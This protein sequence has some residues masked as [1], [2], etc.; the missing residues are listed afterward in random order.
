[1]VLEEQAVPSDVPAGLVRDFDFVAFPD[2]DRDVHGA[3]KRVQ[4]EQPDLFWTPRNGGH[5]VATRAELIEQMYG[6][7]ERF[8]S[9]TES[10]PRG[11][12]PFRQPPVEIDPP[13]HEAYR[14]LLLPEFSPRAMSGLEHRA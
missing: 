12:V 3:W 6:N 11:T 14:S 4:D 1:M 9:R 7:P 5:W 2:S 13:E 8:S 10:L